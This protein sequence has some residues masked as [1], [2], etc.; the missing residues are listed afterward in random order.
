MAKKVTATQ[1]QVKA[2][3]VSEAIEF[4]KERTEFLSTKVGP[5]PKKDF[6][7]RA[8]KIVEL[9]QNV[10]GC[11]TNTLLDLVEAIVG[12]PLPRP[13]GN[14]GGAYFVKGAM[15]ALAKKHPSCDIDKD[16]PIIMLFDSHRNYGSSVSFYGASGQELNFNAP[17]SKTFYRV[18]TDEEI[19]KFV[20][21]LPTGTVYKIL[22][23]K[24]RHDESILGTDDE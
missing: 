19:E 1:E 23:T 16:V 2:L 18:A 5:D 3:M 15:F 10:G 4:V 9:A 13:A 17:R 24:A 12:E 7:Q 6:S 8:K 14:K 21:E 22:E 11:Q 20:K